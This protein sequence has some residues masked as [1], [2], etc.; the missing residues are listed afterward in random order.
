MG[1]INT[2]AYVRNNPLIY[3][4]PTG[5]ILCSLLENLGDITI[6]LNAG[7]GLGLGVSGGLSFRPVE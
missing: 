2:Y 1:G 7:I 4:D 3:I 5:L 6:N